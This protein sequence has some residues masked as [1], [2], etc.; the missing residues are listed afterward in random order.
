MVSVIIPVY[1]TSKFLPQCL[2]SVLNQTCIDLDVIIVNDASTDKS[3][4]VCNRYANKDKRIRIVDKLQN[5]GVDRARFSG[6]ALAKGEYVMFIDSDDWLCDKDILRKMVDKAEG[7]GVDYVE[8]GMQQ[9]MDRHGW[10]KRPRN[11]SIIGL[12]PQPELF[13][14]FY[15]SFFGTY[16]L[17]VNIWG[18]LYRKSVLDRANLLPSGMAVGEDLLFNMKLFPYLNRI[19]IMKDVGYNYRFGG[20]TAK[21]NPHLYPDLKQLYLL[22]EQLIEQ[23]HYYIASNY[24]KVEIKNALWADICQHIFYHVGTEEEIVSNISKELADPMWDRVMQIGNLPA[25]LNDPFI[26]AI[27]MKDACK[28]YLICQEKV[29]SKRWNKLV[30]RMA[31]SVLNWL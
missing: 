2:D 15:I 4:S 22:R 3:L 27:Q 9:V 11:N 19:Y 6:L 25:F 30:K 23:Y 13:N 5:E 28:M 21:Y 8:M 10:I 26:K 24:N 7:T 31:L 1:N 12:I 20:M 17:S 18:K 16:I 14:K 29:R